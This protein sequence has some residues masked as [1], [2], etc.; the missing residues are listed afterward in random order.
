MPGSPKI[1]ATNIPKITALRSDLGYG[2]PSI[3]RG[4]AFVNDIN[5]FR[6][7]FKTTRGIDG[8]LL[9][10]WKAQ[11]THAGLDE[12]VRAY[13]DKEGNGQLFWPDDES[14]KNYNEY[15]YSKDRDRIRR[16]VK[17]LFFRLNLQQHLARKYRDKKAS[18]LDPKT[19]TSRGTSNDIDIDTIT[20]S[21]GAP[22]SRTRRKVLPTIESDFEHTYDRDS[23]QEYVDL[24]TYDEPPEVN[25]APPPLEPPSTFPP[26]TKR[27]FPIFPN[28]ESQDK[29]AKRQ[30]KPGNDTIASDDDPDF[31]SLYRKSPRTT[32]T[33]RKEG[34][35]IGLDSINSIDRA[36][37][38]DPIHARSR[39]SSHSSEQS[40]RFSL[41]LSPEP[42]R[43]SCTGTQ[44]RQRKKKQVE[45][46]GYVVGL[47]NVNKAI[48]PPLSQPEKAIVDDSHSSLDTIVSLPQLPTRPRLGSRRELKSPPPIMELPSSNDTPKARNAPEQAEA[49]FA[50]ASSSSDVRISTTPIAPRESTKQ[51]TTAQKLPEAL[52]TPVPTAPRPS[53][54]SGIKPSITFTYR[55]VLSRTPRTVTERWVPNGKFQD[56]T[57]ADLLN[58]LPFHSKESKGLIFTVESDCMR[59][60]ERIEN[61]E[62]DSFASM[63]RYINMEIRNWFHRQ[64]QEA[65]P[66]LAVDIVIEQMGDDNVVQDMGGLDD[67][68]LEW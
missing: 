2:D 66:R 53:T 8:D 5:A 43:T 7:K 12:M 31:P 22:A 1:L 33:I 3:P 27:P 61:D 54:S 52:P 47:E 10:D 36:I 56:K 67:L 38:P 26:R 44:R 59:T 13:L 62:E 48:S 58:E 46:E 50:A 6:R 32:K 57:L 64:R 34:Y 24:G 19:E 51:T 9:H 40:H 45:K 11:A 55:I 63:K 21:S 17:F 20:G 16:L 29:H 15:Q 68:E 18:S 30:K 60:V 28:R 42:T 23:D 65:S 4:L 25:L 39:R 35:L 49:Y 14:A 41:S 37:S